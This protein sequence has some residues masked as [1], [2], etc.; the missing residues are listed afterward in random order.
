MQWLKMWKVTVNEVGPLATK[1]NT[2]SPWKDAELN[3]SGEQIGFGK[4]LFPACPLG[5]PSNRA[6]GK[7]IRIYICTIIIDYALYDEMKCY[8]EIPV[9]YVS[10]KGLLT[11]AAIFLVEVLF[12]C[13]FDTKINVLRTLCFNFAIY[14]INCVLK[15]YRNL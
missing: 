15:L 11:T 3:L 8:N 1:A 12:D 9:S 2:N 4:C 10:N 5:V 14:S 6:K 7:G 13:P